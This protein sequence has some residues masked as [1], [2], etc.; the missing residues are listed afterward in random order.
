M[1]IGDDVELYIN[2]DDPED[3]VH[4]GNGPIVLGVILIFVGIVPLLFLQ[5]I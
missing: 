1:R 3:Y 2:K 5:Y 4:A